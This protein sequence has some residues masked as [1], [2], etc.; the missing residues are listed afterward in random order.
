MVISIINLQ[1][2]HTLSLTNRPAIF[3]AANIS[4]VKLWTENNVF[5]SSRLIHQSNHHIRMLIRW[6]FDYKKMNAC[7]TCKYY[8]FI[9]LSFAFCSRFVLVSLICL[10]IDAYF[11]DTKNSKNKK[12][13]VYAIK[14]SGIAA[15]LSSEK[16]LRN[17]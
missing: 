11:V 16:F 8:Y 9:F 4:E 14:F 6:Y 17:F 10:R 13:K 2:N 15:I 5:Q 1:Y 12:N 7:L 3:I